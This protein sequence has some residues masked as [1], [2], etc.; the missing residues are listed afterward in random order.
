ME[1]EALPG[2]ALPEGHTPSPAG[3]TR[4]EA[5]ENGCGIAGPAGNQFPRDSCAREFEMTAR[6]NSSRVNNN[7]MKD[8]NVCA[9]VVSQ[10]A[11]CERARSG[12]QP[13][14][15]TT[16]EDS[17]TCQEKV[18]K[19]RGALDVLNGPR[20]RV[21]NMLRRSSS[22]LSGR[23]VDFGGLQIIPYIMSD[24][25]ASQTVIKKIRG[26]TRE[27]K[28]LSCNIEKD[29]FYCAMGTTRA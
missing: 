26:R 12:M 14:S 17:S 9:A 1:P 11:P 27:V 10:R 23:K 2:K 20:G 4:E 15:K 18:S 21:R 5:R 24:E 22:I 8:A 3:F 19:L 6:I 28:L 7:T 13:V 16:T 29:V 25:L